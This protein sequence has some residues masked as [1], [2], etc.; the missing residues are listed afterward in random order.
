[1]GD[2][3][4]VVFV[5]PLSSTA[6]HRARRSLAKLYGL[7]ARETEVACRLADGEDVAEVAETMALTPGAVRTRL[8]TVYGKTAT[9]RQSGLVALVR[10]IRAITG[11]SN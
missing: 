11:P 7:T 5:D 9:Q 10:S 8:K 6:P 4:S 2:A 3:R 1:L